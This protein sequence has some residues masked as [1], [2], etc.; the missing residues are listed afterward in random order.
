MVTW[1]EARLKAQAARNDH[2]KLQSD[3]TTHFAG[4]RPTHETR[5]S[6]RVPFTFTF[7]GDA[8]HWGEEIRIQT[9]KADFLMRDTRLL[10]T[11]GSQALTPYPDPENETP[12]SDDADTPDAAFIAALRGGPPVVSEPHTVWPVLR[13][14]L[15]ALDSARSGEQVLCGGKSEG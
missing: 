8:K 2:N 9:E 5:P 14:T 13:F 15:A 3:T 10:W 11:D 6:P 1:G 4:T 12:A 7:V